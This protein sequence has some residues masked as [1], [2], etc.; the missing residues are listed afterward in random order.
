MDSI[1]VRS[2]KPQAKP[3]AS[4][5]TIGSTTPTRSRSARLASSRYLRKPGVNLPLPGLEDLPEGAFPGE[6]SAAVLIEMVVGSCRPA[7][8]AAGVPGCWAASAL[9]AA[10]RDRVLN[11]LR[12][13]ADLTAPGR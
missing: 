9:I 4:A 7:I 2:G 8:E 3:F 10:V 11:D 6:D 5:T 13:A 12:A 1:Q